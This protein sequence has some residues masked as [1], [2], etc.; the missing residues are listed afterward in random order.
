MQQDWYEHTFSIKTLDIH[1]WVNQSLGLLGWEFPKTRVWFSIEY[2]RNKI[3]KIYSNGRVA[4]RNW[5]TSKYIEFKLECLPPVYD[6]RI[7]HVPLTLSYDIVTSDALFHP[8]TFYGIQIKD[9]PAKFL[10]QLERPSIYNK[11]I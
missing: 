1:E 2:H 5:I 3:L 11:N 6:A 10:I 8:N 9:D 7:L 4:I